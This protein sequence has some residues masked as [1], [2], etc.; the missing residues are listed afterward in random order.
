MGGHSQE[1]N[2]IEY[3][4]ASISNIH[5]ADHFMP[6]PQSLKS[7]QDIIRRYEKR[8]RAVAR[9][10]AKVATQPRAAPQRL[11]TL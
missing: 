8:R 4:L 5:W 6:S 9:R 7:A 11:A 2:E 1:K 3:Y 10:T